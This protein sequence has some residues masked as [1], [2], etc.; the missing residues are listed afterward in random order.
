MRNWR[1]FARAGV[2]SFGL[3]AV[4]LAG[5]VSSARG[6]DAPAAPWAA[7]AG[8]PIAWFQDAH[9]AFAAARASGRPVWMAVHAR[10]TA[11]EATW[12]HDLAA[13]TA[14]YR[15]PEI[16]AASRDFACVLRLKWLPAG[17][18][19]ERSPLHLVLD[20]EGRVL[21][22][23]FGWQ[24]APGDGS[25]EV[26]LALLADGL[27]RHGPVSP[28]APTLAPDDVARRAGPLEPA[29]PLRIGV[30]SR[31]IRLR[32]RFLLPAPQMAA[33][34]PAPEGERGHEGS[35]S[36]AWELAVLATW[37]GGEAFHLGRALLQPG[38]LLDMPIDLVFADH[39]AL[40]GQLGVG[41]HLVDLFVEGGAEVGRVRVGGAFVEIGDGPGGGGG[42]GD[43]D[44]Q[45]DPPPDPA[46][47][48]T[49]DETPPPEEEPPT[50]P[51]AA[52]PDERVEVVEPFIADGGRVQ[53]DDALVAIELDD[54]GSVAPE[55]RPL[56]SSL[57][58]LQKAFESEVA[59]GRV[60]AAD[61]AF[62]QRYFAALERI[63][64]GEPPAV[65][66]APAADADAP[67]SAR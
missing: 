56:S 57:A 51:P 35:G 9:E 63:V 1:R 36:A 64:R 3:F 17:D 24:A 42:G 10:P 62:L 37:D 66:P 27:K 22:Q 6:D 8:E 54:V 43:E 53:K 20:A 49:A 32:L 58:A 61:R 19:L 26:L 14:L 30:D 25:A 15:R 2:L 23:R 55:R 59:R 28:G 12:P 21:L 11:G 40:A 16:V 5:A 46:A 7:S 18:Q 45:S 39:P 29:Q 31:G 60:R 65:E 13:W 47:Q 41:K 38:R 44:A 67:G 4:G 34:S 48:Q 52:P 33:A 50:E